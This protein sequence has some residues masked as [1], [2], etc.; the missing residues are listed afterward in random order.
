MSANEVTSKRRYSTCD[1]IVIYD[2]IKQLQEQHGQDNFNIGHFVQ[3]ITDYFKAKVPQDRWG[4]ISSAKITAVYDSPPVE[5]TPIVLSPEEL[6][7]GKIDRQRYDRELQVKKEE[8][9]RKVALK[10]ER[11][12]ALMSAVANKTGDNAIPNSLENPLPMET[13]DLLHNLGEEAEKVAEELG[14]PD[15]VDY[16][17]NAIIQVH[18]GRK[19]MA[20]DYKTLPKNA[21]DTK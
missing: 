5:T 6:R 1:K 8:L 4:L 10:L 2:R 18:Q 16:V 11:A 7:Q 9:H 3:D 17:K 20:N 12:S 21:C 14:D 15:F 19:L 13:Y